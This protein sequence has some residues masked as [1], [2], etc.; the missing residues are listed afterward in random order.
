MGRRIADRLVL[1]AAIVLVT[2]I[3]ADTLRHRHHAVTPPAPAVRQAAGPV[4]APVPVRIRLVPSSTAFLRRCD[5]AHTSL[6]LAPGP[7][8]VLRYDGPPCHLPPLRLH[9]VVRAA[10]GATLYDGPAPLEET[11]AGNYGRGSRAEARLVVP[12]E[13]CGGRASIAGGGLV[14]AGRVRC[15]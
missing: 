7:L 13:A 10:D 14:A 11:L 8:L 2:A 9:A 4:A 15:P 5:A 1:G 6:S 12:P 3:G